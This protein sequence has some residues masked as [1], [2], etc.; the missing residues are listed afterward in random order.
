MGTCTADFCFVVNGS[1]QRLS[2]VGSG[3][4]G[5]GGNDDDLGRGGFKATERSTSKGGEGGELFFGKLLL[6]EFEMNFGF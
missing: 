3:A 1:G 2:V 6:F 4:E 5:H